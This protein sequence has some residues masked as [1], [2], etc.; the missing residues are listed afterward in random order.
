MP[1]GNSP[2][3]KDETCLEAENDHMPYGDRVPTYGKTLNLEISSQ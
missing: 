3:E 2:A 1:Q